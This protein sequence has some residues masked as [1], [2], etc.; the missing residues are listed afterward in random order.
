MRAFFRAEHLGLDMPLHSWQA[1]SLGAAAERELFKRDAVVHV[2][3]IDCAN[4]ANY[5]AAGMC[6]SPVCQAVK[7]AGESENLSSEEMSDRATLAHGRRRAALACQNLYLAAHA[8]KHR[9]NS[10]QQLSWRY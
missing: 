10:W 9:R 7:Y 3:F 4:A 1:A 8:T 2:L 5:I 6:T